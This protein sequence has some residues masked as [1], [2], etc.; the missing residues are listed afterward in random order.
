MSKNK[1]YRKK[2]YKQKGC[3]S[4][5][6]KRNTTKKNKNKKPIIYLGGKS[7]S[8]AYTPVDNPQFQNDNLNPNSNLAYTPNPNPNPYPNEGPAPGGFNF[9]N[10]N[11]QN[12]GNS[13]CGCNNV[14]QLGGGKTKKTKKMKGGNCDSDVAGTAATMTYPNGLVGNSWSFKPSSWPSNH[15]GYNTYDNDISRQMVD[16]GSAYPFSFIRGGKRGKNKSKKSKSLKR[17]H[18]GGAL[19]NFLGQDL[20]DLGQQFKYNMNSSYNALRGYSAPV[21]PTPWKDQLSNKNVQM[22]T[23][24]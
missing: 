2:N 20:I 24:F 4:K 19:S 10:S 17:K 9:L 14:Q 13:G 12:G 22:L 11:S 16:V 3:S 8:L 7:S 15:L 1:S 5:K 21:N 6:C 23:K 18:K